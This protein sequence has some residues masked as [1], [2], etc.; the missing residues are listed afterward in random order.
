MHALI[1]IC[2]HI[3]YNMQGISI[4]ELGRSL[5]AYGKCNT[6]SSLIQ[7]RRSGVHSSHSRHLSN[8]CKHARNMHYDIKQVHDIDNS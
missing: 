7:A 6:M 5:V 3:I 4:G 2:I 1:Y 8:S